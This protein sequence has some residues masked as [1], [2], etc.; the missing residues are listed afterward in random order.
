MVIWR[1]VSITALF[2]A[3]WACGGSHSEP[4][5]VQSQG[6]EMAVS[7]EPA[8]PRVGKNALWV[9]LLDGAGAPISGAE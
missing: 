4:V 8:E 9:E 7:V 5:T 1:T 3:S 6:V 2:F